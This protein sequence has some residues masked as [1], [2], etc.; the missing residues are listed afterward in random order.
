MV[1]DWRY[2]CFNA[3]FDSSCRSRV[4][5]AC[6]TLLQ[7]KQTKN[8]FFFNANYGNCFLKVCKTGCKKVSGNIPLPPNLKKGK[9]KVGYRSNVLNK[10][11]WI[12]FKLTLERWNKFKTFV[13]RGEY[14]VGGHSTP[15]TYSGRGFSIACL[16]ERNLSVKQENYLS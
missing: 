10:L 13:N 4:L 5:R 16:R 14:G 2:F 9:R 6:S 1:K 3:F 11:W 12:D 7:S 8:C 15:L